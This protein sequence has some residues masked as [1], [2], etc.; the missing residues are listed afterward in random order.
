MTEKRLTAYELGNEWTALLSLISELTDTETGETRELTEDE[1]SYLTEQINKIG[2]DIKTKIDGIC[3]VH[4]NLKMVAEIAKAEK[5]TLKNEME[6]LTKRANAR[7]NEADRVK[8]LLAYLMNKIGEKKIKTDLFS[9]GWQNTAKSAKPIE[10]FFDPLKIPIEYLKMELSPSAI[11]EAIADGK[12][13]EKEG[14]ENRTKL[15]YRSPRGEEILQGV[16]YI[17]GE[18]LVI[19]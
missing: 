7:E 8:S 10:G 17:G 9:V 15:F 11:K 1:K 13:Y 5:D 18:T 6:R 4:K 19:K 14:A 16:K 3:K 12:L 2:N